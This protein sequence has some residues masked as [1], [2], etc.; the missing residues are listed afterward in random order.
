[1]ILK[2]I[3][4]FFLLY[5]WIKSKLMEI[6]MSS[7][8]NQ[9]EQLN[10][11]KTNHLGEKNNSK[12]SRAIHFTTFYVYTYSS[13]NEKIK[14]IDVEKQDKSFSMSFQTLSMYKNLVATLISNTDVSHFPSFPFQVEHIF[15]SFVW[16]S[17]LLSPFACPQK[18]KETK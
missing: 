2:L 5:F 3:Y 4:I 1:M 7:C 15:K 13:Q 11:W 10:G 18:L 12:K 14:W 17:L 16:Y 6:D 8:T 9:E